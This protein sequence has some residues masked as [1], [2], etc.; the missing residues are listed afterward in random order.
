MAPKSKEQ[1]EDMRESKRLLIMETALELFAANGFHNT[2]ISEIAKKAGMAKGLLYNYFD[3]KEGLVN[4]I[5]ISGID[6]FMEFFDTNKDGTLTED[7]F[8]YFIRMSF[9]E[10]KQ[11]P[12]YWKLFFSMALQPIVFSM[13]Q[14]KYRALAKSTLKMMEEYYRTKGHPNPK[15][16]ALVLGAF[17]DGISI[18][19]VMDPENFQIDEIMN[20]IIEHYLK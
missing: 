16:Q 11:R 13:L 10:L 3:S 17:M 12:K 9:D 1:F 20:F 4:E 2:S 5:M 8:I 18:N 7:E 6:E 19:Y 14:T 15:M